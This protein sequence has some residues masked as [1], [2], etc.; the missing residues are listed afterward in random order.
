MFQHTYSSLFEDYRVMLQDRTCA[1][2]LHQA[3]I[4]CLHAVD[5]A[6][7][8]TLWHQDVDFTQYLDF[9]SHYISSCLKWEVP[10]GGEHAFIKDVIRAH[11]VVRPHT[12][13]LVM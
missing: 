5:A 11:E 8:I 1:S 3:G 4:M 13:K 7:F 6:V 10:Q 2:Y 9:L 12:Y